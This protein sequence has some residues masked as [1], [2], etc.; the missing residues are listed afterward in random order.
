MIPMRKS[1]T[2]HSVM[3]RHTNT[4]AE[5][6]YLKFDNEHVGN[7]IDEQK[8]QTIRHDASFLMEGEEIELRTAGN[9][10]AFGEAI[11]TEI[12]E[13]KAGD[14]PDFDFDGHRNY[15]SFEAFAV[16]M[17]EYY[18]EQFNLD[19]EFHLVTFEIVSHV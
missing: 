2:V 9:N 17:Y 8:T 5:E 14:I 19:S 16:Q 10:I 1:F 4:M 7:V 18:G 3:M 11:I 6:S 13:I 12:R 15:D